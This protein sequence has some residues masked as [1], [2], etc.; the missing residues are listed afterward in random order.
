[1]SALGREQAQ[2]LAARLANQRFNVVLASDLSRARDT[3]VAVASRWHTEVRTDERWRE[4][5]VGRWDGLTRPQVVARFPAEVAALA[6]GEMIPIGGGES[7]ADLE[8][9]ANDAL[10]DLRQSLADGARAIVFS[11]GGLIASVV[12]RRL[13]LSMRRPRRLGNVNNTAMT[14]LRFDDRGWHLVRYNDALHLGPLG[15]WSSERLKRGCTVVALHE[16]LP[17]SYQAPQRTYALAALDS[18]PDEALTRLATDHP[19]ERIGLA[20]DPDEQ[21]GLVS[22]ILDVEHAGDTSGVTHVV[23]SERGHTLAELNCS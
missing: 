9:R 20:L 16:T 5:D 15:K 6:R 19:G 17:E 14:T 13:G 2:L 18:S 7:W 10:E 21:R 11:H 1:M 8:K 22:R 3:G 23:A 12:R 4:I